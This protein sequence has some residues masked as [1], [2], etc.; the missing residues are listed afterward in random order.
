MRSPR[1]RWLD[2]ERGLAVF[3]MVE[4][5]TLD[6]W[7]APGPGTPLRDA[8]L[9]LGGFAAPSFLFMAG[10]SQVLGDASMARRGVAPSARRWRALRRAGWLLAVAYAFRAGEYLLGGRFRVEGGWQDL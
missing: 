10:L 4:V 2:A 3:F 5:H 1:Q 8:L 9:M 7:L 6:A